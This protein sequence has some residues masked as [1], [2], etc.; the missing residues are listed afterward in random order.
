MGGA[1]GS[2]GSTTVANCTRDRRGDLIG[3]QTIEQGF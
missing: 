3:S 2:G 1:E